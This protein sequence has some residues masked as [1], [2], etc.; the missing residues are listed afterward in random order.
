[1]SYTSVLYSRWKTTSLVTLGIILS[2]AVLY[3]AV[4]SASA[5]SAPESKCTST[6]D[7]DL[8]AAN[9]DVVT[10]NKW[11]DLVCHISFL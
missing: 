11:N 4:S 1:M 10:T 6:L 2:T 3:S 8:I 5:W 7:Q 9:G